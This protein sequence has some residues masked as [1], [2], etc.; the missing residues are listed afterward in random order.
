MKYNCSVWYLDDATIAEDPRSAC[1]D[2]DGCSSMLADFGLLL[3][4]S[5]S[6]LVN[7]GQDEMVLLCET[8][9][10]NSILDKVSIAKKDDVIL[11]GSR[12]ISKAI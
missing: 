9:C 11:L 6:A 10:I 12:L 3:D 4:S 1:D 8:Q 2:I 5:K 7:L